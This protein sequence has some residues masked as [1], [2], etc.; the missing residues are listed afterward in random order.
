MLPF[1]LSTD[2]ETKEETKHRIRKFDT[3]AAAE[4]YMKPKIITRCNDII[5][6]K[7]VFTK[8]EQEKLIQV[9][10]TLGLFKKDR[11]QARLDDDEM[12]HI[13]ADQYFNNAVNRLQQLYKLE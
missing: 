5:V 9:L 11:K 6:I 12:K 4:K 13:F 1:L 2:S 10:K 7:D 3:R 8:N